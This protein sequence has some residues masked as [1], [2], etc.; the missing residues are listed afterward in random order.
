MDT[1]SSIPKTDI[2]WTAGKCSLGTEEGR[3]EMTEGKRGKQNKKKNQKRKKKVRKN[4]LKFF[5]FNL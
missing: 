4:C 5:I 2:I 3:Q 1:N